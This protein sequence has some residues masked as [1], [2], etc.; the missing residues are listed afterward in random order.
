MRPSGALTC[1]AGPL[2]RRYS[3]R[4]S[5]PTVNPKGVP[6]SQALRREQRNSPLPAPMPAGTIRLLGMDPSVWQRH[7]S[8][9]SVYSRL[10]TLPFLAAAIWSHAVIG[11]WLA[12]LAVAAVSVW[13]YLNPRLFPAPRRTDTWAARATFGERIWLNR[14]T[15]PIPAEDAKMALVLS[16]VAASGF[17]AL[18]IGALANNL[19]VLLP[20]LV[21]TYA[22][23]IAFLDRM[24]ALYDKMRDAHPLYRFW[25]VH[26]DNDN[27]VDQAA[28]PPA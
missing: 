28:M 15:V 21:V 10:A 13:L 7:A 25:S 8:P 19:L 11:P 4:V 18:L 27:A 26:P 16:A 22:G 20:G 9:W 6:M 17:L 24:A 14:F 2:P 5:K 1:V 23:K 12:L 3:L